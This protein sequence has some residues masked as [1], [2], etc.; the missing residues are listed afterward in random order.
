[1]EKM[2][3]PEYSEALEQKTREVVEPLSLVGFSPQLD[4]IP[5]NLI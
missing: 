1:M 2:F 4:K 5:S 3:L